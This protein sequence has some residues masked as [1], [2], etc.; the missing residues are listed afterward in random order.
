[1][2]DYYASQN[3]AGSQNGSS[4]SRAWAVA[5]IDWSSLP[6]NTL[7]LL[8]TITSQITVGENNVEIRGD[9][10]GRAAVLDGQDTEDY[11]LYFSGKD[12]AVRNLTIQNAAQ[13]GLRVD[14]NVTSVTS[15]VVDNVTITGSSRLV[16]GSNATRG[17]GCLFVN[18][19]LNKQIHGIAVSN[20]TFKDN[21]KH[22]FDA[23]GNIDGYVENCVA[24][25]NGFNFAGWGFH[26]HGTGLS[27]GG[28]TW[29]Q[30]SGTV[31]YTTIPGS[32]ATQWITWLGDVQK[33]VLT[34]V[35]GIPTGLYEFYQTGSTLYIDI[36]QDPDGE[37]FN[38][39]FS[40][41]GDF[42]FRDCEARNTVDYD[43]VEGKGFGSDDGQ[44]NVSFLR[45]YSHD[46]EGEGFAFNNG[47]N[48][49][50]LSSLC[51]NNGRE[52]V[53]FI[54][55]PVDCSVKN[56]L[57]MDCERDGIFMPLGVNPVAKN[58]ILV[59]CGTVQPDAASGIRDNNTFSGTVSTNPDI[60]NN[61]AYQC[62]KDGE[63]NFSIGT[64]SA[65]NL[66]F[67][68]MLTASG[69]VA[70]DSPCTNAGGATV[71]PLNDYTGTAFSAPVNMGAYVDTVETS[72]TTRSMVTDV[73]Q[74]ISDDLIN[75][76]M[77]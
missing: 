64:P 69:R 31:Y 70:V 49:H 7:Y 71:L 38:T 66:E 42:E 8:D 56:T 17:T 10:P 14:S 2:T 40:T 62:G 30:H 68:P 15:F 1:M 60:T 73:I 26:A 36:G 16:S 25:G 43:G 77:Q 6:G 22:G 23:R 3:G 48:C 5:S 20:C 39:R 24:D 37:T 50:V 33:P 55:K 52:G 51:L 75:E 72:Q 47:D 29:T 11:C 46:N 58:N 74:P 13:N 53:N 63:T 54:N 57:L 19:N 4:P 12:G 35:A 44:I 32:Y 61:C 27:L 41:S 28:Y 21:G 9:Y 76:V 34:E 67:D 18:N 59:R 45:C 65:T